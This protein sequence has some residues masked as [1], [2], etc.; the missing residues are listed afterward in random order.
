VTSDTF[1]RRGFNR[2]ADLVLA[3]HTI[4]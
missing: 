3:L 4:H 2:S 1:P